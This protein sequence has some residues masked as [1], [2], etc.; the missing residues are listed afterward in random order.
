MKIKSAK[1]SPE[2]IASIAAENEHN[3]FE[4][5]FNFLKAHNGLRPGCIH[6]LL[7]SS[8][9]GKSSI[10]RKIALDSGKSSSVMVW[11]SEETR[12]DFICALKNSHPG[13]AVGEKIILCEEVEIEKKDSHPSVIL[14]KF[15]DLILEHNPRIVILDNLTTSRMYMNLRPN[16]QDNV[17]S[18]IKALCKVQEIA[19]LVV[20]HTRSDFSN[21]RLMEDNDVRGSKTI[22]NL[23]EYLYLFQCWEKNGFIFPTIRIRKARKH[24]VESKI[25]KLI[26]DKGMNLYVGD[27]SLNFEEFKNVFGGK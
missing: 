1:S 6:V 8:G 17:V 27:I 12:E 26:F 25:Y 19:L 10:I 11:L 4:S 22:A 20:M 15:R 2:E 3:Y 16:E 23:C 18:E 24:R 21:L 13:D 14:Q 9:A 7:A 5:D